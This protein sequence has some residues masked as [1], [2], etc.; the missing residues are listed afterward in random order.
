MGDNTSAAIGSERCSKS[1]KKQAEE[2]VGVTE[3]AL[4]PMVKLPVGQM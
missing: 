2:R 1:P 3:V 4:C